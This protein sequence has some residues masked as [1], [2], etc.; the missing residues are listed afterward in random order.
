M[1]LISLIIGTVLLVLFVIKMM[2]G[3][4]FDSYVE[5]L[6]DSDYPLKCFYCIGFAWNEGELLNLRGKVRKMLISQAKLLHNPQYAE[7]YANVVW[8]QVVSVV[9]LC[10]CVGFVLGGVFNFLFSALVGVICAFVFGYFFLTKMKED[11]NKRKLECTIELPEIVS[12]MALLINSG[13][14][15]REAWEK[16]AYGKEGTVYNLMQDACIDMQ[17]GFSEMD[18]IYK[19]GVM[20][21]SPEIK[22]FTGALVQ[23]L[24]KG[25]RDLSDFLTKQSSEM[26][27]LKKQ[28]M[29]QKGEAAA[30]KLL[31]PI[32]LIFVGILI[33][34]ISAAVGM[35][36]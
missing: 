3:E 27:A 17:N 9:H 23:G 8:A 1:Q 33:I 11:L 12:T 34:V 24:S 32:A 35:L 20:S 16:I 15:L 2:Q 29:L 14:V 31:A 10:L 36:I 22:K 28:I 6:D 4:S 13:M 19:F 5:N 18:A 26:W 30:S 7:Y 25:S 21:D